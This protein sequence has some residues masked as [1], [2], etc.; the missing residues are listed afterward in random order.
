MD[1]T[2]KRILE[3]LQQDAKLTHKELAAELNLS[4]TPVFERVKRLEQ[5]GHIR[6]YVALVNPK[7]INRK[8][9]SYITVSLRDHVSG[10]F[11]SFE[12][13]ILSFEEVME[14]YQIAGTA[15][16]LLKVAVADME[17]YRDFMVE[18]LSTIETISNVRSA[19]VMN[20][21]KHSTA[22]PVPKN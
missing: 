5:S 3:L 20:E 19:F 10:H 8:L 16:Y 17:A 15:D 21:I 18:R 9:I 14:C 6:K 4:V 1:H 11:E 7:L 22:Y 12:E 2:D 13:K